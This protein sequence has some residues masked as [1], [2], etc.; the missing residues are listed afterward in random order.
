MKTILHRIEGTENNY[1]EAKLID[2]LGGYNMWNGG[3]DR[4]GYYTT[5]RRVERKNGLYSFTLF[6]GRKFF[7]KEVKRKSKK[8]ESEAEQI[9]NDNY[10]DWIKAVYPDIKISTGC[11]II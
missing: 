5:I 3:N 8:A 2:D 6:D 10:M 1:I 4:R 7:L 9:M 11:T